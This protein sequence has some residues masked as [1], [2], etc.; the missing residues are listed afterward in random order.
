MGCLPSIV[1]EIYELLCRHIWRSTATGDPEWK[2]LSKEGK[3][4]STISQ[5]ELGGILDRGRTMINTHIKIIKELGWVKIIH[6]GIDSP[7]TYILGERKR[8]AEGKFVEVLYADTWIENLWKKLEEKAAEV[9]DVGARVT[10][11]THEERRS[12]CNSWIEETRLPRSLDPD[13][14]PTP[15]KQDDFTTESVSKKPGVDVQFGEQGVFSLA[16]ISQPVMFTT[17]NT[18]VARPLWGI[19]EETRPNI[20]AAGGSPLLGAGDIYMPDSFAVPVLVPLGQGV[21]SGV[22]PVPSTV[23]VA[24]PVLVPSTIQV[25][26]PAVTAEGKIVPRTVSYD[27]EKDVGEK[28]EDKPV[29]TLNQRLTAVMAVAKGDSV[30]EHSRTEETYAQKI[31]RERQ[32]QA[33][34]RRAK[35]SKL[36]NFDG[37]QPAEVRAAIKHLENIWSVE[38]KARFGSLAGVWQPADR[39]QVETLLKSYPPVALANAIR[40]LVGRWPDLQKRFWKGAG[41]QIPTIAVLSKLH[42]TIVPEGMDYTDVS[43][44]IT[45]WENWYKLN[46]QDDPPPDLMRRYRD[47]QQKLKTMGAT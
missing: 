2:R 12:V 24:T 47:A 41:S 1:F 35:E 16:N 20:K 45:E 21:N 22:V 38:S 5:T 37:S 39:K 23:L 26:V 15:E 34:R 33:D 28:K 6:R 46:P 40:Y 8:D 18:E 11:L 7:S 32:R 29:P 42:A 19:R 30:P 9:F 44:V 17:A 25:P 43:V 10:Q 31:Q 4:A 3:L 36:K 27:T 13:D 14:I